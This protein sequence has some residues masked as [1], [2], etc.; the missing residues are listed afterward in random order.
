MDLEKY[1]KLILDYLAS[2]TTEIRLYIIGYALRLL[3]KLD[4]NPIPLYSPPGEISDQGCWTIVSEGYLYV[5]NTLKEVCRVFNEEY[6][7]DQHLVG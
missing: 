1:I 7:E 2:G 6:Q 5:G 4:H 3:K